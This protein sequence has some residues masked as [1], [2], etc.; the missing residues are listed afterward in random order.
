VSRTYRRFL[1]LLEQV[2]CSPLPEA[3]R[4]RVVLVD[5]AL[6]RIGN[7]ETDRATHETN[8]SGCDDRCVLPRATA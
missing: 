6:V 3:P 1:P 2:T 4:G 5:G 7:R 8:Y